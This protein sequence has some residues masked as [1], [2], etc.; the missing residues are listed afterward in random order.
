MYFCYRFYN[1]TLYK[2]K[3]FYTPLIIDQDL[4]GFAYCGFVILKIY[5]TCRW[6]AK[7]HQNR[8]IFNNWK[9]LKSSGFLFILY[10][11][12]DKGKYDIVLHYILSKKWTLS[13]LL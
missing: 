9:L 13:F 5:N 11:L 4:R 8:K 1:I 6:I 3:M 10:V 7:L 2:N 12:S